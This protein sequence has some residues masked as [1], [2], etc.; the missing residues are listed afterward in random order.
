MAR[1]YANEN[2]PLPAVTELRRLGHDVLTV[3]ETGKAG[4]A[5]PDEAVLTFAREAGR[6]LLIINRRHFIRLHNH[7]AKHTGEPARSM[8][9]SCGWRN[10]YTTQLPRSRT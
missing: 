1:L 4:Q 3:Q 10:A 2:F 5:I 8:P 6:V 9:T 7:G